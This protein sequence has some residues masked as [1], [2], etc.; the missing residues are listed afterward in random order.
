MPFGYHNRIEIRP[1]I[2][3][4]GPDNLLIF[5]TNLL[6]G[7]PIARSDRSAVGAKFPLPQAFGEA[8][9]AGFSRMEEPDTDWV[10]DELA[11]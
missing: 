9:G 6:T 4:L 5:S 7:M 10:A 1:H 3:P 2:D 8:D 11:K